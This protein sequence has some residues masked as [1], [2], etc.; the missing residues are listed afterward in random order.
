VDVI[1]FANISRSAI[2]E[3]QSS[4]KLPEDYRGGIG[5]EGEV[6]LKSFVEGGGTLLTLND[7]STLPIRLFD[8]PLV[9]VPAGG[10]ALFS[11][12]G[13]G[14]EPPAPAPEAGD[15]TPKE[16]GRFDIPGAI[17]VA[18]VDSHHPLGFGCVPRTPVFC[19]NDRGFALAKEARTQAELVFPVRYAKQNLVACGFTEGA[20]ALAGQGAVAV[21][22]LGQGQAVLFSFSPQF[23]CQTW[24]TFPLFLNA[25]LLAASTPPGG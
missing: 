11:R 19:L 16:T 7:S 25:L 1:V 21:A 3:G 23:R 5:K 9:S 14:G 15:S 22:R 18:E 6:A 4:P 12:E 20:Q 13:E 17:L 10:R 24:A 2:V 8:L